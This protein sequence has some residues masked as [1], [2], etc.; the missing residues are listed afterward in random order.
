LK[1]LSILALGIILGIMLTV[2]FSAS[3][4]SVKQY[5]L[6]KIGYP[7]MVNGT[8]LKNDILPSLNYNGSTYL[9]LKS[10]SDALGVKVNWNEQLKVVEI[11]QTIYKTAPAQFVTPEPALISITTPMPT[12]NMMPPPTPTLTPTATPSPTE[13]PTPMPTQIPTPTPLSNQPE[14]IK[15]YLNGFDALKYNGFIFIPVRAGG[16]KYNLAVSW[17]GSTKTI[18]IGGN[19]KIKVSDILDSTVDGFIYQGTSYVKED[20]FKTAS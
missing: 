14:V 10:V 19:T 16:E 11:N 12:P 3:A 18:T 9:P 6:T 7:I 1:K 5:I 20:I 17:D 4:D 2:S 13:T 15:N 8:E